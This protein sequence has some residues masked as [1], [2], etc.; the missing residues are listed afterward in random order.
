MKKVLFILTLF[1]SFVYFSSCELLYPSGY[2]DK[3]VNAGEGTNIKR[4]WRLIG[5]ANFASYSTCMDLKF[6]SSGIPY[7]ATI[8]YDSPALYIFDGSAWNM[9]INSTHTNVSVIAMVISINTPYIFDN[10]FDGTSNGYVSYYSGAWYSPYNPVNSNSIVNLSIDF[11]SSGFPVVAYSVA[12]LQ[13]I[14]S[15]E[16]NG[17]LW[18]DFFHTNTNNVSKTTVNRLEDNVA[19]TWFIDYGVYL[20]C[21]NSVTNIFIAPAYI[22][23]T[24]PV[25][26][27]D[28]ASRGSILYIACGVSNTVEV[29][30]YSILTS[31]QLLSPVLFDPSNSQI[32]GVSIAVDNYG[33]PHVAFSDNLSLVYAFV[34]DGLSWHMIGETAVD[35]GFYPVIAIN[36]VNNVPYVAYATNTLTLITVKAF[37]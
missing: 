36:P 11:S 1:I 8:E 5:N 37:K 22:L 4:E 23:P 26:S 17:S 15:A 29:Y 34:Y 32:N 27:Y 19:I 2:Y 14:H 10:Y 21:T 33:K 20:K 9:N 16:W 30:T 12:V 6:G 18:Q 28:T 25:N 35:S 3:L 31:Y 7:I 24:Y 13:D